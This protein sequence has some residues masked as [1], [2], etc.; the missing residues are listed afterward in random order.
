[1]LGGYRARGGLEGEACQNLT[2]IVRNPNPR[3]PDSDRMQGMQE[4]RTPVLGGLGDSHVS[5]V[6]STEDL[7]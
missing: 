6:G 3:V 7:K 4:G 2:R 1:M 5:R